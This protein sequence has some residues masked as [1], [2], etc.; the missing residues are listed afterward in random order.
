MQI[1]RCYIL[2]EDDRIASVDSVHACGDAEAL[3]LAEE[4]IQR[5]ALH[6]ALEVWQGARLVGRID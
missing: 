3:R 4:R 5:T 6:P 1:Y 2:S